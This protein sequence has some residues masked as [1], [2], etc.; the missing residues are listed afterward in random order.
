MADVPPAAA[1]P[2]KAA[3]VRA[4]FDAIAQRYDLLNALLSFGID[5]RWRRAAVDAAL[6][7]APKTIVDVATG[8]ADLA[9]ALK[10]A[11][12][13]SRVDG[14]DLSPNMLAIG[15]SKVAASGVHVDLVEGD[16]TSLDLPDA[17][18]DAVTI[19]FGLRNFADVDAG[20][21]ECRRVLAPGGRLVVLEFPPPPP[22]PFGIVFRIYF[23]H[24]LPRLG[25]WL[26]G[27]AAAYTYLPASVLA[28]P[29]PSDLARRIRASGFDAVT[30][31]PLT[32][33]VAAMHVADVDPSRRDA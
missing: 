6:A 31:T 4:M 15:R 9:I 10:V 28:F 16:G 22:G 29:S 13:A 12:P 18:V 26:S 30:W 25:R 23:L 7:K 32:F 14:I 33:G 24:V 5:R 2:D 21:A 1:H 17:S 8:T 20:L 3:P 27:H 11:S 19:A